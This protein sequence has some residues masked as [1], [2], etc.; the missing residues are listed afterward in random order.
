MCRIGGGGGGGGGKGR[1][2]WTEHAL[3]LSLEAISRNIMSGSCA[4][5]GLQG[6]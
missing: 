1:E 2:I 6:S 5:A 3:I 4:V